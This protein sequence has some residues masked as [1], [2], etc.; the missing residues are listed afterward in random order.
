VSARSG[1]TR[2]LSVV[3]VVVGG[4][5]APAALPPRNG[6]SGANAISAPSRRNRRGRGVTARNVDGA[7]ALPGC[8]KG[9]FAP[10]VTRASANL[11]VG[12]PGAGRPPAGMARGCCRPALAS[13]GPYRS[14]SS[15]STVSEITASRELIT[16]LTLRELRTRYK[17]SVLGWTWS[18]LNPLATVGIYTVVFKYFFKASAPVGEPSGVSNFAVYLL[19]GLL[20]WNYF[21]GCVNG[22][23]ATLVGNA[24]LIKKVYFPR[25]GLVISLVVSNLISFLI[26]LGVLGVILLLVGSQVL[27]WIPV[28]LLLVAILT[29]FVT[30]LGLIVSVL[31]VYFR[32]LQYL[33]GSILLQVLFY[34]T[35]IVYPIRFVYDATGGDPWLRRL[36]TANPTVQFIEA[37]HRVLYDLRWPSLQNFAYLT[38]WAVGALVLGMFVFNRFESRLA[39]EL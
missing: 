10:Y 4:A 7:G 6:T 23:M 14:V 35:P 36:Y 11:L 8:A 9:T 38:A 34:L 24:G 29:V 30:G 28:V 12:A 5:P 18:M 16:N 39:E 3:A 22:A 31:N 37:F 32:D 33:V 27:P 20:A 26:E 19:C 2:A 21:S 13:L 17:R 15:V 1:T 25:E